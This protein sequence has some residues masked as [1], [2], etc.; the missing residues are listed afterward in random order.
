MEFNKLQTPK[1]QIVLRAY[2]I[3]PLDGFP[4]LHLIP[5]PFIYISPF[6]KQLGLTKN[7]G[8]QTTYNYDVLGNLISVTLPDAT[9]IEYIVDSRNRRVGKKVNGTLEKVWLYKDGLIPVA[10]L[11]GTGSVVSRF[12]YTT[13]ANVPDF[14]IKGGVTYRIISDHLGSPRL[15]VDTVTG[16]VVQTM[17]YDEFGNV[18][19]DTNPEFQPFGFAGGLYDTDTKLVRFGARD[20]DAE[21]GRWTSKDPIRFAG[22][23]NNLYGYVFNDPINLV[24]FD[25]LE[26]CLVETINTL[27]DVASGAL[28]GVDLI[29]GGPTGEGIVPALILQGL[30]QSGKKIVS[31]QLKRIT[32]GEV[33]KLK[34]GNVNPEALKGKRG[35]GKLDIF[36]DNKG[37]L[38]I[39]PK[40][41]KGP[42]EPTGLNIND[43]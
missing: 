32:K 9:L 18:I 19:A 41:G 20:Y 12:V 4:S 7:D 26:P 42:G 34:K 23:D 11:D 33:K 28:I 25:G 2:F 8:G 39:K 16:A 43:F 15:V 31:N 21:I 40:S 24:D 37:N 10:E 35:V 17:D 3:F 5:L 1:I 38:F 13:R 27:I 29:L 36:K 6:C 30:K 22:G 14:I